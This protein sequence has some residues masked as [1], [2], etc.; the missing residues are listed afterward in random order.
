MITF[1][2][3]TADGRLH[4]V[5]QKRVLQLVVNVLE[6]VNL[7]WAALVFKSKMKQRLTETLLENA[8]QL[9]RLVWIS[10]KKFQ[11][12]RANTTKTIWLFQVVET[13]NSGGVKKAHFDLVYFSNG[14]EKSHQ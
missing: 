4:P 6:T 12:S 3:Q 5:R 7:S 14:V 13:V 9:E 8:C 11:L 10:S 2:L 1:I